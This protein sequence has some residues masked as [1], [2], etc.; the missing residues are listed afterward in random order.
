M[1]ATIKERFRFFN[2]K[3]LIDSL[4][5]NS[6]YLGIG[7][8]YF[9]DL[10][11]SSDSVIPVPYDTESS[12][13]Q[14]WEDMMSLKRVYPTGISHAVYKEMWQA[15]TKYDIYRHDWNGSVSSVYT[16]D[17]PSVAYPSNLSDAKWYVVNSSYDVY[18]C[19]KQGTVAGVIQDSVQS[20]ELGTPV[21]ATGV[22]QTSDGYLWKRIA[23][24]SPTNQ[25]AFMTA[26]YLPVLTLTTAPGGGDHYYGQWE[27]QQTSSTY[28]NGIY[29][30]M[31]TSGGSGYN[32]GS[33]GTHN[34][35]DAE[36]DT[37]LTIIG[38]GT[39]LQCTVTYTAGGVISSIDVTN[40][41]TGYTFATVQAIGG[42][43]ATFYP[44]ITNKLGVDPVRDLNAFFLIFSVELDGDEGGDFTVLNDYRKI[45][46]ISNPCNYGTTT[47]A[48][49][50]TL[51]STYSITLTG[52]SGTFNDDTVVSATGNIKG[53]LV[54][55]DATSSTMRVI[56]TN[57]ENS[58]QLGANNSF[59]PGQTVTIDPGTGT[60]TILSVTPPEVSHRSGMIIYSEYRRPIARSDSQVETIKIIIEM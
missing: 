56:R 15:N 35:T 34:V 48:T 36:T 28:T 49:A 21:G 33:A 37:H 24:C 40:P 51:D 17:N 42:T 2:A 7:R 8:P 54:D 1:T 38:N 13:V 6:L 26:D 12:L 5:T 23:R 18:V 60:G 41:G 22:I 53:R 44:I 58:G 55:W 43:G 57:N 46:L 20:P 3:N 32:S 52:E 45:L 10:G 47:V 39:G 16:G 11:T 14:D 50:N 29:N 59:A 27:D 19:L 4:S 31:V 9:W 25:S 30:I